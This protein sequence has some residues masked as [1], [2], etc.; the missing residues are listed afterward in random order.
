MEK[1]VSRDLRNKG[2]GYPNTADAL[3]SQ[4]IVNGHIRN[5][6]QVAE[7]A[8]LA[9][10][11]LAGQVS[12]TKQS[13]VGRYRCTKCGHEETKEQEV[14]CDWRGVGEMVWVSGVG[15]VTASE[16]TQLKE[17]AKY[18][19]DELTAVCTKREGLK[20]PSALQRE[21]DGL[22]DGCPKIRKLVEKELAE[23]ENP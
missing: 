7:G 13:K 6:T 22:G 4:G 11:A 17:E 3:D 9:I 16:A 15:Q 1:I 20:K 2:G 14:V 18:W 12:V 10:D 19:R 8:D 23:K 5:V 21:Y